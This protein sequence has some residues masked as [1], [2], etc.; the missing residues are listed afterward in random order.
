VIGVVLQ[1]F[2]V[3]GITFQMPACDSGKRGYLYLLLGMASG[4]FLSA[5]FPLYF[6]IITLL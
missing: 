3:I 6:G 1:I 5:I 4:A 2:L